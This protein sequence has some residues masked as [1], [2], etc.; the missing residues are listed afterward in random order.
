[1]ENLDFDREEFNSRISAARLWVGLNLP[2]FSH[3]LFRA[4]IIPSFGLQTLAI[5]PSWRIYANPDFVLQTATV[6]LGVALVHEIHHPLMGHTERGKKAMVPDDY[7]TWNI[8]GDC[9]IN[10]GLLE[11]G[12]DVDE[13]AWMFPSR[14]ELEDGQLAEYYYR[15]IRDRM[16]N[17]NRCGQC[18]SPQPG[19]GSDGGSGANPNE[20]SGESND[21]GNSGNSN[22]SASDEEGTGDGDTGGG[23]GEP[24]GNSSGGG[25]GCPNCEKG[26]AQGIGRGDCGSGAGGKPVDGELPHDTSEGGV[27]PTEGEIIRRKTASS[28]KE[29]AQKNRGTLPGGLLEWATDVLEPK[30]DWRKA[31]SYAIRQAVAYRMGDTES[32]YRRLARRNPTALLLPGRQDP[33]VHLAAVWDTS[34]S[35]SDAECQR[36]VSELEGVLRASSLADEQMTLLT[37]STEVTSVERVSTLKNKV[38]TMDRGGTDMRVGIEKAASL[39]PKP[40]IILV[41]TDGATPWPE[42]PPH[43]TTVIAGVI[44]QSET[45]SESWPVP[46]YITT[47]MVPTG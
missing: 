23:A 41:M 28:I 45:L 1:M 42:A 17:Q 35:V 10:D 40:N 22:S 43:N 27:H 37:V 38:F 39:R 3:A 15:E 18:G 30:V 14:F 13:K 19:A 24:Q 46:D 44:S 12:L 25:A 11:A 29:H 4:R 33:E 9:E 32:T 21:T 8:A 20:T 36:I 34:G 2:Y 47:V 6:R 5:D 16:P 7:S 26:T 31:L